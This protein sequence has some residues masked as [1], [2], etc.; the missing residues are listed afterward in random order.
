MRTA[1]ILSEW[2]SRFLEPG[3]REAVLGDLVEAG[4]GP[5]QML[6]GIT[7][8]AL[9]RQAGHWRNWRPWVA[10]FGVSVPTSFML[11]G[12]SVELC[13]TF[14]NL[15][16]AGAVRRTSAAEI[17]ILLLQTLL[18]AGWSWTCGYLVGSISRRTVW[19][20]VVAYGFPCLFCLSRFRIESLSRLSLL[21]FVLPLA[22][23]LWQGLW[24]R[25]VTPRFG[26]AAAT[27]I[28]AMVFIAQA[29]STGGL[30]SVSSWRCSIVQTWPAWF[31]AVASL[32]SVKG[33]GGPQRAAFKTGKYELS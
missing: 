31:L 1:W 24:G 25:R 23:G 8:L 17:E 33:G 19:L 27:I 18:L 14:V 10:A 3:E 7:G 6:A 29:N 11:M 5:W 26:V 2:V 32:N 20:S 9:R 15:A 21:L 12:D 22:M 30:G 28:T 16:A 4:E 13:S